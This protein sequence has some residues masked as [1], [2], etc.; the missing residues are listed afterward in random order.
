MSLAAGAA[1]TVHAGSQSRGGVEKKT[2]L[3][4][5]HTHMRTATSS[6]GEK[7]VN[8][9]WRAREE[10]RK[11]VQEGEVRKIGEGGMRGV[12]DSEQ[13]KE[14]AVLVF[15]FFYIMH[16]QRGMSRRTK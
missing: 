3:R 7:W 11:N 15:F 4:Q 9:G 5:I 16:E 12:E 10:W 14:K 1:F 2:D 13:R 8:A 6:N